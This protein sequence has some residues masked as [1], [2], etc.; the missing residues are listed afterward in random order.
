MCF[1]GSPTTADIAVDY[2]PCLCSGVPT[3]KAPTF[4]E[5]ALTTTCLLLPL[6]TALPAYPVQLLYHSRF[7]L[8]PVRTAA[9]P[10]PPTRLPH[11]RLQLP[12]TSL[13]SSLPPS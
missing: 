11:F 5:A 8:V 10:I 2:P 1:A 12:R 4:Q 6:S 7:T 13:P 3:R 9:S